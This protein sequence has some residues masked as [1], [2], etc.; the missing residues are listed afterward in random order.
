M[1]LDEAISGRRAVREYTTQTI[2][3]QAIR[4][5]IDGAVHAPSAINEQPW[6]FTVLRDQNLLDRVSRNAKTHMLATMRENPHSHHF[7]ARLNDP[8]F[9]IFYHA[10]ALIL[11]SAMFNGPWIVEDCT[12][13]AENLMLTAYANGFGSCWIG[14]AQSFLNTPEGKALLDI[15][16]AWI[17]VAPIIVG[18]ANATPPPVPRKDPIIRWIG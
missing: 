12:L 10:P 3:E 11:I 9:H 1:E 7:Q 18:Y 6:A 2:D 16:D 17:P 15:P 14:F 13:A 4:R 8:A 5:L